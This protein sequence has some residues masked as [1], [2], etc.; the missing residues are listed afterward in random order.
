MH[1]PLPALL[2]CCRLR[3]CRSCN[4]IIAAAVAPA[5]VAA[6]RERRCCCAAQLSDD[7]ARQTLNRHQT[8]GPRLLH[9]RSLGS[10]VGGIS[11]SCV[12]L[13]LHV[14]VL[15]AQQGP[16]ALQALGHLPFCPQ[17]RLVPAQLGPQQ[18]LCMRLLPCSWASGWQ[19]A[20]LPPAPCPPE[21]ARQ[22]PAGS[23]AH[24]GGPVRAPK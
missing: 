22:I 7:Q 14:A 8:Q 1:E 5:E 9:G 11:S 20:V 12:Q 15:V 24:A 16:L 18:G 6:V 13:Q 2:A 19:P 10:Q 3:P 23:Q 17:L 4:P 21:T